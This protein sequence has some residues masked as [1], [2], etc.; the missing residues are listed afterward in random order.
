MTYAALKSTAAW[1]LFH[2]ALAY[3]KAGRVEDWRKCRDRVL[4]VV[5]PWGT[6]PTHLQFALYIV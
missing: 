5:P 4:K 1:L 6:R 3:K 2:L